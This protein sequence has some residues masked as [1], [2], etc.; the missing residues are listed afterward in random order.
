MINY[1]SNLSRAAAFLGDA[2]CHLKGWHIEKVKKNLTEADTLI[3][4]VLADIELTE[5]D[6][7]YKLL[8]QDLENLA[9]L[10]PHGQ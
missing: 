10:K 7:Q 4:E 2:R 9:G 5:L 6:T 3:D 1:V 8:G